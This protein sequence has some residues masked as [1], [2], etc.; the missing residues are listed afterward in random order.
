MK[1]VLIFVLVFLLVVGCSNQKH[2]VDFFDIPRTLSENIVLT[3]NHGICQCLDSD[4]KNGYSLFYLIRKKETIHSQEWT[5]LSA[6]GDYLKHKSFED[7][8]SDFDIYLYFIDKQYMA[9]E[10][11]FDNNYTKK[12]PRIACFYFLDFS[13]REMVEISRFDIKSEE[14]DRKCQIWIADFIDNKGQEIEEVVEFN[15]LHWIN[16]SSLLDNYSLNN[17]VNEETLRQIQ[18]FDISEI[19]KESPLDK[20]NISIYSNAAVLLIKNEMYNEA[21]IMLLE[22]TEKY[23][24]KEEGWLALADAQWGNGNEEDAKKSYKNYL[25][26]MKRYNKDLMQLPKRVAERVD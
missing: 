23:P 13:Q 20:D 4:N 19:L 25:Y 16:N 9:K 5:D 22:I 26:L 7:L 15:A 1:S 14:E 11:I 3:D 6:Y 24:E 21:R 2:D 12:M 17:L 10:S 18:W 8:S